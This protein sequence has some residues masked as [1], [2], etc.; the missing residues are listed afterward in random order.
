MVLS[1]FEEAQNK[2]NFIERHKS[3]VKIFWRLAAPYSIH[4]ALCPSL[5]DHPVPILRVFA[6]NL[7]LHVLSTS[8]GKFVVNSR[9]DVNA[10]PR[11]F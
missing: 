2:G 8:T 9:R 7:D 5:S 10:F 6:V 11:A 1:D 3:N 4:T